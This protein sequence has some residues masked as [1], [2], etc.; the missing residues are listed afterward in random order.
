MV[1]YAETHSRSDDRDQ[2]PDHDDGPQGDPDGRKS[3]LMKWKEQPNGDRPRR[4][5]RLHERCDLICPDL[6]KRL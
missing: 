5:G 4:D 1:V 2:L 3:N 6:P